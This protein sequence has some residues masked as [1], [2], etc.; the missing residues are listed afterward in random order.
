[1]PPRKWCIISIIR[2]EPVS[3]RTLTE[4]MREAF[5]WKRMTTY[6]MLRRGTFERFFVEL[7]VKVKT[8]DGGGYLIVSACTGGGEQEFANP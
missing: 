2:H 4:A 6:T 8:T 1:M 7:C 5:A 3:S